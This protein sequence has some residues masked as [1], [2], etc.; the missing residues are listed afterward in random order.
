MNL[1]DNMLPALAPT[2]LDDLDTKPKRQP[3]IVYIDLPPELLCKIFV[4]CLR[5]PLVDFAHCWDYDRNKRWNTITQVCRYWRSVALGYPDLW[6]RILF[7]N[8]K[9]TEEMIRR[10]QGTSLEVSTLDYGPFF[11]E[12]CLRMVLPELHRVSHLHLEISHELLRPL[13]Y[14]L[15]E[16]AKPKLESLYL[17][18]DS[19]PG[20]KTR[21]PDTI[22]APTLRSL[23]L[24]NCEFFSTSPDPHSSLTTSSQIISF[25]RQAPMLHTL[26]LNQT[27]PENSLVPR[28]ESTSPKLVLPELSSLTLSGGLIACTNF[29]DHLVLPNITSTTLICSVHPYV[30]VSGIFHAFCSA[31]GN[32]KVD[33]TT[34]ALEVGRSPK[35]YPGLRMQCK[36]I[37]RHSSSPTTVTFEFHLQ[38]YFHSDIEQAI[39]H[40]ACTALPL[41]DV[42]ELD[43]SESGGW[44]TNFLELPN[45]R[46]IRFNT[47]ISL[48]L[49]PTS[50][51]PESPVLPH[52]HSLQFVRVNFTVQDTSTLMNFLKSRFGSGL[53]IKNVCLYSCTHLS[54][55]DM[56]KM[57]EFVEV[58]ELGASGQC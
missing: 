4:A 22:F 1:G 56:S 10:S 40:V 48:D 8:R 27:L 9:V 47:T 26:V 30:D 49:I 25:L 41:T 17:R 16:I 13:L 6:K 14:R 3:L 15:A 28:T 2:R 29:L 58:V 5:P 34:S 31:A 11:S 57:R 19:Y 24:H 53:P 37:H 42:R 50:S 23:E 45:L 32:G 46:S 51:D 35:H 54:E 12:E 18:S 7:F 52:L 21:V 39:M 33:F 55:E 44:F 20:F 36:L 38:N 43:I